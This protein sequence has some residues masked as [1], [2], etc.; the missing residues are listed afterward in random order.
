MKKLVLSFAF[1]FLFLG[2]GW[3]LKAQ[4]E[5]VPPQ[6]R[7]DNQIIREDFLRAYGHVEIIWQDYIIYADVV[8]FNQKSNELFAEGRVTMSTKDMVL[9]GE[10]LKFNLKTH[11]GELVDTY[12]LMSP[13]VRYETDK[14]TQ[15]DL[16]T[17]TFKRL[18]FSSCAQISPRWKITG[19]RGKIK[20][21]KYIAMKDV[22]FRIKNIPVFYLPYLRYPIKKDGRGTGFLFPG[23]GNSAVRGFN[24]QPQFFWDI[25]P[26]LDMTLGLDYYSKLGTGVS[27][28]VRYLFRKFNGSARFYY[29]KYKEGNQVYKDSKD[30]YY[31]EAD[32]QQTLPFLNS[33]LVFQVKRQSRPDFL[34]LFDNNFNRGL[35]SSSLSSLAWTSSFANLSFSASASRM[36]TFYTFTNAPPPSIVENLPDLSLSL[37]QQKLGPI[38][39]FFSLTARYHVTFRSGISYENEPE[40]VKDFRSQRLTIVPSYQL[41]LLNL[42]WLNFSLN[43]QSKNSFY[44]KSLDPKNDQISDEPLYMKYQTVN[45]TLQG[46]V[47]Q[48]LFKGKNW[49]FKHTIEPAFE[50]RYAT[51]VENQD[52]LIKVDRFDYP[53]FSYVGFSLTSRLLTKGNGSDVSASELLTYRIAQQYYFDAAEANQFRKVNGIYPSFSELSNS[54]DFRPIA[55]FNLDATLVYNYYIHDFSQLALRVSYNRQ[56]APLT[57]SIA[58]YSSK[59]PYQEA[60]YMFNRSSLSGDIKFE[61]P[62]FPFKFRV[63]ADYDFRDKAFRYG[64]LN[65]S[66]DYQCII[67]SVEVKLFYQVTSSVYQGSPFEFR[68]GFS[69]G[70]LGMVSNFFGGK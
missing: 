64:L 16:Q 57:G 37:N 40:Y 19:R 4:N 25:R 50:F 20:K 43:L 10:K 17:L 59:N 34:S 2:P 36:E 23:I 9:S 60:A 35:S 68:F 12:G 41:T 15:V 14:L 6:I 7:A 3:L 13:F 70:N 52:R 39:G 65:A 49:Q 18:D 51:K 58:F 47:L 38:P 22:L 54:L 63:A 28:E 62:Q 5:S 32:H 69:L 31:L 45:A 55:D 66:F 26:N 30:D 61:M 21:E 67:F 44:P 48:R 46:P 33:N 8:E 56:N 1:V 29:F 24:V 27:D 53:D 11:S 42:P